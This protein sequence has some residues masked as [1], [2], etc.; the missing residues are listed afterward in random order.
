MNLPWTNAGLPTITIPAGMSKE[1]LP[2]GLQCTAAFLQDEKLIFW[3]RG[4]ME[5]LKS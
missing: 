3:A 2:F 4:L 1:N 5:V